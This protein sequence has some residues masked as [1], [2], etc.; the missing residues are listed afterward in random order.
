VS[1]VLRTSQARFQELPDYP[2]APHY[3][4]LD[5]VRMH[6]VDE[7]QGPLILLLH[8]EPTWSFLYRHLILALRREFRVV[9]PDLIG[10]GKSDKYA[11][12]AAYTFEMH[13]TS[14]AQF[15][16]AL[17]L[18]DVTLVVHDWGGPIGLWAATSRPERFARLV[19]LNTFLS[20]GQSPPGL[21]FRLWRT[22]ARYSP[23]FPAGWLVQLATVRRLSPEERRA[24]DAPFPDRASRTGARVF[25]LLVPAQ[26]SD[27]ATPAMRET[28]RALRRWQKPA[29]VAF[30]DKDPMLGGLDPIFRRL[31]PTAQDQP[32]VTIGDAGHF[33]QEDKG[34]EIANHVKAFIQRTAQA[35]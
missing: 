23:I 8:G 16:E 10:F 34:P 25:P 17:D 21:A 1:D 12:R 29:L 30:S 28:F 35:S 14:F 4:E 15:V 2:F 27:P 11:T 18:Q 32:Q 9:A 6:Y 24:Y 22:F 19:I 13:R 26:R 3:V 7:G 31:I 5:Q 33:L 20:T